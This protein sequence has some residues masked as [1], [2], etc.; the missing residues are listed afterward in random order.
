MMAP[1]FAIWRQPV[2]ERRAG[3]SLGLTWCLLALF[4]LGTLSLGIA[5][6]HR[7]LLFAFF[8]S[9]P[10]GML[11]LMWW[12]YLCAN[13]AAQCHPAALQLVPRLRAHAIRAVVVAWLA[14][15]AIMT[16]LGGVTTGHAGQVAIVTALVLIE[17]GVM[18][19]FARYALLAALF[20]ILPHARPE[21]GQW[22]IGFMATP[23]GLLAGTLLVLLDGA[24]AL[25]RLQRMHSVG[26][27][28][29]G[30]PAILAVQQ[31]PRGPG[32]RRAAW[33][34]PALDPQPAFLHPLGRSWFSLHLFS[35]MMVALLCAGLRLWTTGQGQDLHAAVAGQRSVLA[36][37]MFGVLAI[38]VYQEGRRFAS[39]RTEQALLCLTPA[40]P[41]PGA[42]NGI[43]AR[44]MLAGYTRS[45][46]ILGVLT[47]LALAALGAQAP[48]LARLAAVWALALPLCA[49]P[50]RDIARHA[51]PS[52]AAGAVPVAVLGGA[53]V[54]AING[55][56]AAGWW[57]ALAGFGIAAGLAL[58]RWRWQAMLAAAPA[59]PAGRIGNK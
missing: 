32:G 9:V 35:I 19:S 38:I 4:L 46:L 41:G 30:A 48:E 52:G 49:W 10:M 2:A 26:P 34:D 7:T 42:M 36:I 55:H 44:G 33:F 53:G 54:A 21:V 57:L 14:I 39:A 27:G 17:A 11:L 45:W 56:G 16:L 5:S 28:K 51:D 13:V 47:L 1:L 31:R 40:A 58:A 23:A 20:W 59:L 37:A 50:M 6:P 12:I 22:L 25:R 18:G 29:P 43:L 24:A 15:V 3:G 8:T